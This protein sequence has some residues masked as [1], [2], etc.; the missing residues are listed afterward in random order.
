LF[1][2]VSRPVAWFDR[3]IVDGTMNGIAWLISASSE[4]I[5]GI[6]SGQLQHYALAF[7]SGAILLA[8]IALYNLS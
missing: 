7:V 1:N 6:Q 5:K 2:L 3:H 8:L 4:K